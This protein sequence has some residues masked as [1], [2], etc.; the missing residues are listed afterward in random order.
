MGVTRWK[1][2]SCFEC[3]NCGEPLDSFDPLESHMWCDKCKLRAGQISEKA[4]KEFKLFGEL[5]RK[6]REEKEMRK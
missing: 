5:M 2:M 3:D 6:I 1:E 4:R